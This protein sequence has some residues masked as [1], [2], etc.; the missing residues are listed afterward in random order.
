[1]QQLDTGCFDAVAVEVLYGSLL[2]NFLKKR[3][4]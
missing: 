4:K 3:Q 1:M 2:G